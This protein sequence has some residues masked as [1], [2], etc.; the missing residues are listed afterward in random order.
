MKKMILAL[1]V[2]SGL[3]IAL[4]GHEL[5]RSA[6]TIVTNLRTESMSAP[7]G[8]DMPRP[9]L[10]WRID[11]DQRGEAQTAYRVLVASTP[12]LL[13]KDKGD[14]WDSGK[15]PSTQSIQ[16]EYGGKTLVA[17][18]SYCWKVRVWCKKGEAVAWSAISFFSTGLFS[19]SDW[20]SAQW[21]TFRPE[22]EWRNQW[23]QAVATETKGV[24]NIF[25]WIT[26]QGRTIWEHYDAARPAYDPSPL[27]RKE[28]T[29]EWPVR[30]AT[31]FICGLGYYE[32]FL[33]GQRVGDHVLDPAWTGY[34]KRA[35]YVAHDVTA[36]LKIGVNALGAMLGRG[37]FSPLC[38]DIW[39]LR[40]AE[41]V[42]QPRL[43]ARLVVTF[44]DGTI[45][46]IMTDASWRTVGGPVIYDDTRHGEI[47]D[48]R[49]E[50]PGWSSAGFDAGSW[51]PAAV[52][53][54]QNPLQ[55]QL[56]PPIREFPALA[57]IRHIERSKQEQL[58]DIGRNLTGWARVTV[59]GPAGAKVL[60]DYAEVP[61]DPELRG[62]I[63]YGRSNPAL[64]H[65]EDTFREM[66][67]VVR[68]QNGYILKGGGPETFSCHFS[69]KGF[70]FIRVVAD[71]GVFIGHVEAVPV[72]SDLAIVG[73]FECSNPLLNKIQ[74][75]AQLTFLN[76]FHS[77]Q[78]DCPHREKQGWTADLYLTAEAAM[79]NF[80]MAGFYAKCVT[81]MADTQNPTGGLGLVAPSGPG[82]GESTLWP[83]S[84]VYVP[85]DLLTFYGD[86]RTVVQHYEAMKCFALSSLKRQVPGKTEIITDALGDWASP[87]D[88]PADNGDT[89]V[90]V[91]PEGRT[92]YGTAAHYRVVNT[93]ARLARQLGKVEEAREFDDW[94][95]R[96]AVAFN[97]EFFDTGKNQ[98][99][100]ETP[101][102]YRQAV[103]AVPLDYGLVPA[104]AR[105]AVLS[106]LV[107]NVHVTRGDRLNTGFVGTPALL[108]VLATERPDIAYALVTNTVYPSW[109]SMMQ[110]GAT[111]IWEQ[112]GGDNSHNH[113]MYGCISSYFF[114]YLAGIRPDPSAP[115]FSHFLI[116][117]SIVGDLTWVRAHFDSPHGRITSYWE[118]TDGKLVMNITM[119]ANTT[120]TVYVPAL[121]GTPAT[122]IEGVTERGKAIADTPGMK[123]LKM[124]S[125]A[126]VLAL[127]SGC[128]QLIR[129]E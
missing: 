31:L 25:P 54:A 115:G 110:T 46:D 75:A 98:Y 40:R 100:G 92:L 6:E 44:A 36:Q 66:E 9:R 58:F 76:N 61:Y 3:S 52:V 56:I 89:Y 39:G 57:P 83:A 30:Q 34:H 7:L 71:D 81:D 63:P 8:L 119:P 53:N 19:K 15:V 116:K 120:A 37:Q 65:P 32:A 111:T 91:P 78:T 22:E 105:G 1:I 104:S 90:S 101:T 82:G 106:Q 87:L 117:P 28:F 114:K 118:R 79:F 107:E 112:F 88:Q 124:E 16:I 126:V 33:N 14:V 103:N 5:C 72:H 49:R 11:S 80:D 51:R 12:E 4:L 41:W 59:Q 85:A 55:A 27:F 125:G 94:A 60:V 122:G 2:I 96:I 113:P 42:G 69:Y 86:R 121:S 77:I 129:K 74:N 23:M 93:L 84:M 24:K 21:I 67:A 127:E 62:N 70:Q 102:G 18:T 38:N 26:G 29:L 64:A 43:I 48:A 123:F 108:E 35:F 47:Y 45:K 109:G 95:R 73:E 128:Y 10:G 13:A 50:Q 97:Q 99:H 68:Q 20:Q 17:A